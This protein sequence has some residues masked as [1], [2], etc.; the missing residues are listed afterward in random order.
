M[1]LSFREGRVSNVST[2]KAFR[3]QE[4]QFRIRAVNMSPNTHTEM[5]TEF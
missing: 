3:H 2:V 1:L 5:S 4:R